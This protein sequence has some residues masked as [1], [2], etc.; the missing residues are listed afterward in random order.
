MF[1][2]YG[3]GLAK[4]GLMIDLDGYADNEDRESGYDGED[5][6]ADKA[7]NLRLTAEGKPDEDDNEED[8]KTDSTGKTINEANPAMS[9]NLLL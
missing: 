7:G 5:N 8:G 6:E 4:F 9:L 3:N 1:N 2:V